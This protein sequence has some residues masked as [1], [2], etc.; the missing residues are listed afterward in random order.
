MNE[1]AMSPTS[2]VVVKTDFPGAI[3]EIMNGKKMRRESWPAGE[4]GALED[5][6]LMIH[7]NGVHR[8]IV[9]SGDF[10]GQ[11]WVVV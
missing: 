4:Y 3:R 11:D 5:G 1:V 9:T 6:L 7:K 10:E 8:W 2:P